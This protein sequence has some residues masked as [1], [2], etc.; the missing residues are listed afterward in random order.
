MFGI[1]D[2]SYVP[3]QGFV[4]IV[5]NRSARTLKLIVEEAVLPGTIID[6]DKW[7]TYTNLKAL[8]YERYAVN[9]S[10][11]FVEVITGLHT[12]HIEFYLAKNKEAK[13][14]KGLKNNFYKSI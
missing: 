13:I 9:H 7:R 2:T 6:S 8:G 3:S 10:V 14:G 12:E 4:R 1:V 11:K 5:P